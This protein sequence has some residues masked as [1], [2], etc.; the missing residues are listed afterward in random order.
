M[1]TNNKIT[2]GTGWSQL[3][4]SKR[5]G[6]LQALHE[7]I[8]HVRLRDY[9]NMVSVSC[10]WRQGLFKSDYVQVL[11]YVYRISTPLVQ[12][13][14][15]MVSEIDR[16]DSLKFDES[17][18]I[19]NYGGA[20]GGGFVPIVAPGAQITQ[21][22]YEVRELNRARNC[23][24]REYCDGEYYRLY[25]FENLSSD[26]RDKLL[27]MVKV[28]KKSKITE[29]AVELSSI[30]HLVNQYTKIIKEYS[31]LEITIV[32]DNFLPRMTKNRRNNNYNIAI[33]SV[34]VII[35][36]MLV[37]SVIGSQV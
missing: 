14:I 8:H 33:I 4:E 24:V 13:F 22:A 29:K 12:R 27:D 34:V 15:S 20:F 6:V 18:E 28:L 10:E 21:S 1:N 5:N 19:G 7:N 36:I 37:V 3:D 9:I 35:M 2:S 32:N 17:H 16:S 23:V 26:G 31:E 30:V 11:K 25:C